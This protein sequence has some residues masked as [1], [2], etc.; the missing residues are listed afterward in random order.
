MSLLLEQVTQDRYIAQKRHL[1][2]IQ[3]IRLDKD[4]ADHDGTAFRQRRIRK[5]FSV[6]GHLAALEEWNQ[7]MHAAQVSTPDTRRQTVDRVVGEAERLV[8]AFVGEDANVITRLKTATPLQVNLQVKFAEVSRSLVREIGANLQTVDTTG[9]FKF[10]V[11]TG[12]GP[13]TTYTPGSPSGLGVGFTSAPDG[14]SLVTGS[15]S[16]STLAGFGKL[17][18][19]DI[20]SAFDL[21]E[22]LQTPVIIM[23]DLDLGMNDHLCAPLSWDDSRR[24]DRGKVLTHDELEAGARFGRYL[25]VDGD[26]TDHNDGE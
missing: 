5:T 4:T 15:G 17:F 11:T 12:R 19:L 18:G 14:G 22:R 13:T 3:T 25:D 1:L 9:G 24:Y 7:A 6:D 20:A 23:S 16:G 21:A 2:L 10:G 26:G 8:Q